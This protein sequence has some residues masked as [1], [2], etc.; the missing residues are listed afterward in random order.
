MF[1]K[2]YHYIDDYICPESGKRIQ[3]RLIFTDLRSRI[4]ENENCNILKQRLNEIDNNFS[5]FRFIDYSTPLLL[6]CNYYL[7]LD[8]IEYLIK[9]KIANVNYSLK[10]WPDEERIGICYDPKH[11]SNFVNGITPLMA[12]IMSKNKFKGDIVEMLI[13]YGA[14]VNSKTEYGHT[15]LMFAMYYSNDKVINILVN[16]GADMNAV[17]KFGFYPLV[18][19]FESVIVDEENLSVDHNSEWNTQNKQSEKNF[20]ELV[21]LG[22]D[23]IK[24]RK[25]YN[26]KRLLELGISGL[27][28]RKHEMVYFV[29][30]YHE[31][32]INFAC[33]LFVKGVED[34]L[35]EY[36]LNE[37]C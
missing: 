33:N 24:F 30:K 7:N 1:T 6:A 10:K 2:N 27:K 32:K 15:P 23:T 12:I 28:N 13:D 25:E 11:P 22:A 9:I 37:M 20:K 18:I 14:N 17:N 21:K 34:P 35:K 19:A 3:P 4:I 36:M 16:N 31:D 26:V 8:F 29:R 5:D